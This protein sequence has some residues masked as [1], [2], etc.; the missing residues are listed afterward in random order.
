MGSISNKIDDKIS[1]LYSPLLK[2]DCENLQLRSSGISCD[3]IYG[4]ECYV[5]LKDI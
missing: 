5:L 4:H 1:S 3:Q 2:V